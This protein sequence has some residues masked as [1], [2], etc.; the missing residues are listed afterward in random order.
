MI[1]S[2]D[3][4]T[5]Y[6]WDFGDGGTSTLPNPTYTY[7]TQGTY[8]VTLTITTSSGCTDDTTIV[9]A[10][11]VGSKPIADFS[12]TPIPVCATEPVQFTDLSVPADEWLWDFG[13]GGGSTLQH[14]T[15]PIWI[16]GI[17]MSG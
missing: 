13:D 7:T 12:A 16:P 4:V 2:L 10:V 15:I 3:A 14:P 17:L 1:T 6:F 9:N 5:S 11:R 8:D